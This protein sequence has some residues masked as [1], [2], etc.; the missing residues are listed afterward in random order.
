[1]KDM[2]S[3]YPGAVIVGIGVVMPHPKQPERFVLPGGIICNRRRA[4]EAAQ[5]LHVLQTT[6]LHQMQLS[7]GD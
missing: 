2:E 3:P 7:K 6:L 4:E 5:T 1:M